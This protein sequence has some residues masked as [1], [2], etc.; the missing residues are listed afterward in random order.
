MW[1]NRFIGDI[2]NQALVTIDGTDMKVEMRYNK[3][4]FSHKFKSGGLRYEVGVCIATGHIVWIHGPFRCG[5]NDISISRTGI[6][7][8]P[9]EEGETCEADNGYQGEDWYIK[10]P[11]GFHIRSD[12][13]KGVKSKAGSRHESVNGRMKIF[14]VLCNTFRHPALFHS[15]CFRAVAVITQINFSLG[16]RPPFQVD[17]FDDWLAATAK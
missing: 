14:K 3:D 6:L 2:G 9:L 17:Y 1:N 15:S 10:T 11:A 4:F 8:G 16:E 5:K 12:K 13:E 7:R